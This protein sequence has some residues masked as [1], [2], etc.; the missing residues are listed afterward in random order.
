MVGIVKGEVTR[1]VDHEPC[2]FST[3]QGSSH[4]PPSYIWYTPS[5]PPLG[6]TGLPPCSA[7]PFTWQYKKALWKSGTPTK[8]DAMTSFSMSC[9][10]GGMIQGLGESCRAGGG[11]VNIL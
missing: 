3:G 8:A 11:E 6:S 9:K 2:C 1:V 5:P 7:C 4:A 10:W